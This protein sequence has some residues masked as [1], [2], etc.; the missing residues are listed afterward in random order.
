MRNL[1]R[2]LEKAL[3]YRFRRKH[4]LETALTHR[5][6]RFE[7]TDIHTDNQRLEYL[8]DAALG[9]VAA[10]Y[11]FN[12]FPDFQEGDLTRIRSRL[13][14][15]KT[16]AQIAG[17]IDLGNNLKLGR[18]EIQSGG[19]LRSSNI[20]DAM[21]AVIGGAYLDG[22]IKAVEKI[23]RKLFIPEIDPEAYDR[24]QDNPKGALQELAQKQWKISPKYRTV[25]EEGPPHAKVFTAEV[26][27]NSEA[28]GV[29]TG[30]NKR[31][32][33]SNA[34]QEALKIIRQELGSN[35]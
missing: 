19:N 21:E 14:N 1:Y 24:W 22:G 33:E 27:V 5:S 35:G 3:G 13:T 31:E 16:L 9:L 25:N 34:A 28:K 6:Y 15:S 11:L 12:A 26:T 8:G 10:A 2:Q 30:Q 29:G 20:G 4:H 17:K 7:S 32:A 18:G 23:F